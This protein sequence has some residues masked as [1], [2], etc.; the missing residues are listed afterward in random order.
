IV[1]RL[2]PRGATN[3]FDGLRQGFVLLG[4]TPPSERQNRVIF[5]SDGNATAGDTSTEHIMQMASDRVLKGIG[6][7]TIGVGDDFDVALMRGLAEQGAGNFYF[8]ED[9]SA[10]TEVFTEE[11]EYFMQPIA[12]DIQLEAIA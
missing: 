7:T 10:A 9:P 3:I 2:Q 12:L 1:N 8:L 4:D 5:L 11:L 6:L